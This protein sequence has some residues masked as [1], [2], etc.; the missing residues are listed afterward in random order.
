MPATLKFP[1]GILLLVLHAFLLKTVNIMSENLRKYPRQ[2]IKVNVDL[3]FLDNDSRIVK[4]RDISEGG[5]F[6]VTE[7][8]DRYPIGEMVHVHYL[9]PFND[10]ADTFKD[11]IIVRVAGDGIAISFIEMDAF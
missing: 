7:N 2:E 3:S 6:L 1:A 10:D 8:A 9:D 11:A 4:T 5:M